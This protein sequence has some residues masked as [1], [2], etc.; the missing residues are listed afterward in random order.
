MK[1]WD[2]NGTSKVSPMIISDN[3]SKNLNLNLV[4][5]LTKVGG[6]GVEHKSK[7]GFPSGSQNWIASNTTVFSTSQPILFIINIISHL[8]SPLLVLHP[9]HSLRTTKRYL[10]HMHSRRCFRMC[11][12][13]VVQLRFELRS[14]IDAKYRLRSVGFTT[15]CKNISSVYLRE[16]ETGS[17]RAARLLMCLL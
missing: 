17:Q 9:L 12:V 1:V 6:G 16:S 5:H 15:S 2:P 4:H 3:D 11:L 13:V 8:L 14:S 10:L 7:S